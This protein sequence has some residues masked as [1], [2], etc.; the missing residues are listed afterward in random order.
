M[1][2]LRSWCARAWDKTLSVA[3]CMFFV[4]AEGIESR[5]FSGNRGDIGCARAGWRKGL[6]GGPKKEGACARYRREELLLLLGG[7]D[8]EQT[9]ERKWYRPGAENSVAFLALSVSFFQTVSG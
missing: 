2:V 7:I 5:F 1:T 9:R 4:I 6:F 8:L 3:V